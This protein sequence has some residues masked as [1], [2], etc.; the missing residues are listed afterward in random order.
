MTNQDRLFQRSKSSFLKRI[1]AFIG[2]IGVIIVAIIGGSQIIK[3]VQQS[4]KI[5][6]EVKRVLEAGDRFAAKFKFNK[7]IEEYQKALK[8]DEDNI[9]AQQRIINAMRQKLNNEAKVFLEVGDRLAGQFRLNKAIEEYQKALE[10]DEENIDAQL[11]IITAIRQKLYL[12]IEPFSAV[13]DVLS[14]IYH[15]YALN[16][17]L[18][19]DIELLLEEARVLVYDDSLYDALNV[20]ETAYKEA[21]GEPEVLALLGLVRASTSPKDRVEG[22][23]LLEQAIKSQPNNALY[24]Y[25]RAQA[26]EHAGNDSKSIRE[27]YQT[28]KLLTVRDIWSNK[29][30]NKAIKKLD[31]IFMLFFRDDGALTSSINI[32]LKERAL[33]YEYVIGEY[34]KLPSRFGQLQYSRNGY[35]ATLFYEL[36]DFEKADQ[37]IRKTFEQWHINYKDTIED[38]KSHTYGIPWVELHIKIL[39]KGALDQSTLINARSYLQ[40]YYKAYYKEKV[41]S[42]KKAYSKEEKKGEEAEKYREILEVDEHGRRYKVGLKVSNMEYDEGIL[43]LQVFEGYPFHKAGINKGDMILEIAQQK[44]QESSDIEHVLTKFNLGDYL[45][46]HI[47]RGNDLLFLTLIIE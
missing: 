47:K 27:Y 38:W 17:H 36:G 4:Q 16:S 25:Y 45:P 12:E 22:L 3:Q 33:I 15:L 30:H 13:D 35:M 31:D 11:K 39:E 14:R 19:N 24:H 28:A 37:R 29:L 43:V 42:K 1:F 2:V 34:E 44:I 18:K 6:K 9:A 10:L 21:P 41:Y 32:P 46:V 20:L 7:A 8:L 40:E 23:D 26:L 5:K